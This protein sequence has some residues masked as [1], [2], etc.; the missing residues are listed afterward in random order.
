M[1]APLSR[2]HPAEPKAAAK[3]KLTKTKTMAATQKEAKALLGESELGHTRSTPAKKDAA[4]AAAPEPAAAAE[5]E[6]DEE[7]PAKAET[8]AAKPKLSKTKTMAATTE[9]AKDIVGGK[10][11]GKTRQETSETPKLKKT[12]TMAATAKVLAKKNIYRPFFSNP[13]QGRRR[14]SRKC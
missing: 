3:P 6:A 7:A 8:P 12:K 10:K 11:R 5:P 2:T 13:F 1:I 4:A 14:V 9:E